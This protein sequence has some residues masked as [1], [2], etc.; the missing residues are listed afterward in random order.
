VPVRG[1]L[2]LSAAARDYFQAAAVALL[3]Q[4]P[5]P[6]F[7]GRLEVTM[8]FEP[9]N[10]IRRD[11]ANFEKQVS[12]ALVKAGVMADDSQIDRLHLIRGQVFKGGRVWVNIEELV[13]LE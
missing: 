13:S 1:R 9:P 11:L 6:Q 4:K 7:R 8:W 2:I 12:D 5:W 10:R 3:Q